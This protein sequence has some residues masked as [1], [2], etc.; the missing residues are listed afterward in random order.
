MLL[1][2]TTKCVGENMSDVDGVYIVFFFVVGVVGESFTWIG[3]SEC[4]IS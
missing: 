1:V 4:F 2:G 3:K